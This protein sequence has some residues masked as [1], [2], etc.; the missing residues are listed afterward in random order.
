MKRK[1]PSPAQEVVRDQWRRGSSSAQ[2]HAALRAREL[3]D[4]IRANPGLTRD[5]IVAKGV[6]TNFAML[7]RHGL[8]YFV[9]GGSKGPARWFPR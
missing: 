4:F 1:E 9:D 8:V 5:Q 6:K 3:L 7:Q 2:K